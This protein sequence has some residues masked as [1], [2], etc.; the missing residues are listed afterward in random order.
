MSNRAQLFIGRLPKDIR[1]REL[2]AIFERYGRLLRCDVKYGIGTAYAFIDY[3]DRRDAEDAI[4]YEDGREFEDQSIVVEWAHGPSYKP[5]TYDECYRC[6]HTGHWARDCPKL[7]EDRERYRYHSNSRSHSRSHSRQRRLST[8][9]SGY[10]LHA[11]G[12]YSRAISPDS[13]NLPQQYST[14]RSRNSRSWSPP[15]HERQNHRKSTSHVREKSLSHSP[16]HRI[17][18]RAHGKSDTSSSRSLS[19]HSPHRSQQD[20]RGRLRKKSSSRTPHGYRNKRSSSSSDTSSSS[21]STS[22]RRKP[23]NGRRRPRDEALNQ[24]S[25]SNRRKHSLSRSDDSS[26]RSSTPQ[27]PK[28]NRRHSTANKT[29]HDRSRERSSDTSGSHSSTP[30]N[31]KR[32]RK[33]SAGGR[34]GRGRSR[35][36][37]QSR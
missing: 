21:S 16:Q 5:A 12:S 8:P 27:K 29:S 20:T 4:R 18:R 3:S 14:R 9:S 35:D 36:H 17:D 22:R 30:K 28:R 11:Y 1:V 32:N 33:R 23:Q 2:E 24:V 31:A 19:P 37:S 15:Q 10:P 13:R 34:T 6:R 26:S 7:E 25:R